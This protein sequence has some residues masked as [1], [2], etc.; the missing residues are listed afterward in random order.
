MHEHV[1]VLV[2]K[3]FACVFMKDLEYKTQT[4]QQYKQIIPLD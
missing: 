2:L 1:N 4:I 3:G